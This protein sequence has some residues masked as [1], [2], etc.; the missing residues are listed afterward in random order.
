M[1]G[2][3][4]DKPLE[5]Y[6]KEVS[7]SMLGFGEPEPEPVRIPELD[8]PQVVTVGDNSALF[9]MKDPQTIERLKEAVNVSTDPQLSGAI[10]AFETPRSMKDLL[11]PVKVVE[12]AK[13]ALT[14]PTAKFIG[15]VGLETGA[16]Y[17][18]A[19]PLGP[20]TA[21]TRTVGRNV[22]LRAGERVGRGVARA[23]P[24]MWKVGLAEGTASML[25]ES[26]DPT[27]DPESGEFDLRAALERAAV[28][29]TTGM[30]FESFVP[31]VN[32][33]FERLA[34]GGFDLVD[35]A[36]EPAVERILDE[37][38]A[39]A[40]GFF[41]KSRLIQLLDNIAAG[42]F[43]GGGKG[44][45]VKRQ[46]AKIYD[47]AAESFIDAYRTAAGGRIEL[48][49]L[50]S[51][52]LTGGVDAWKLTGKQMYGVI[53][54][55]TGGGY[56]VDL[57]PVIKKLEEARAKFG[58]EGAQKILDDIERMRKYG[59]VSDGNTVS[60]EDAHELRSDLLALSRGGGDELVAG[61]KA[62]LGKQLSPIVDA[63]M[64]KAFKAIGSRPGLFEEVPEELIRRKREA[65]AFW[66]AGSQTFNTALMRQLAADGPTGLVD[67]A[68]KNPGSMKIIRETIE[69][70][71]TP[72]TTATGEV[73]TGRQ[74]WE[75]VKGQI[76]FEESR[77][78]LGGAEGTIK[79][80]LIQGQAMVNNLKAKPELYIEAFG[81][82]G[83]QNIIDFFESAAFAQG[84]G[85][86]KEL[87]GRL[88]IQFAQASAIAA[89]PALL[90]LGAGDPK[91]VV[92]GGAFVL[93]GPARAAALL[94]N[95]RFTDFLLRG[96]N[97]AIS[98]QKRTRALAQAIA[99]ATREGF[100]V[101]DMS[102]Q[103][104]KSEDT[105]FG[106]TKPLPPFPAHLVGPRQ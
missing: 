22:L 84:K 81:E 78:A 34:R 15:R 93:A 40:P 1:A 71:D 13:E 59:K 31:G 39:A 75:N 47:R 16:A 74:I 23:A 46:G 7:S 87:P 72:V 99:M 101:A 82:R 57:N 89:V 35:D 29:G 69:S 97:R 85:A 24:N 60:F 100:V 5:D 66:K 77:A 53:D 33:V 25:A 94:A 42:S 98:Y 30:L 32:D 62:A 86:Q 26:F 67:A 54:E 102:D 96:T 38:T 27:R 56:K 83:Y 9:D 95:P 17:A 68:M 63:E 88:F 28:T 64:D 6:E 51:D 19:G 80:G 104:R 12:G 43:F 70:I 41:A 8:S 106:V 76:L 61:K 2:P 18:A 91:E 92:F 3:R 37:G 4:R 90:F 44:K 65:D 58:G 105:E 45:R 103:K 49:Q 10:T 55:L 14:S 36:A 48:E 79:E 11:D 52:L 50:A 73:L 20:A 21:L